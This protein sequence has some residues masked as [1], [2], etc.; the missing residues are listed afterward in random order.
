MDKGTEM[1]KWQKI[2]KNIDCKVKFKAVL[3]NK[4]SLSISLLVRLLNLL[5]RMHESIELV[6]LEG[7]N[8]GSET[9]QPNQSEPFIN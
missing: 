9:A 7:D 4:V 1:N 8:Q 5:A 3:C 2:S 6:H